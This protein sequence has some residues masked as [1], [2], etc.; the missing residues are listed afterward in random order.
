MDYN[1]WI[2]CALR[3]FFIFTML[4]NSSSSIEP[5]AKK[6]KPCCS[7]HDPRCL[8]SM[9]GKV[10]C[11]IRQERR[12]LIGLNAHSGR[13]KKYF[14]DWLNV[15]ESQSQPQTADNIFLILLYRYFSSFSS[16]LI[17]PLWLIQHQPRLHSQ[18]NY[19]LC[20]TTT[21]F[22]TA[23]QLLAS[24]RFTQLNARE[25]KCPW[26]ESC[27]WPGNYANDK[28]SLYIWHHD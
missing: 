17:I 21:L 15:K 8:P 5:W 14:C 1:E 22:W 27:W 11:H 23:F 26:E 9:L 6:R 20:K 2:D 19:T 24:Q 16:F 10:N 18:C 25:L 7:R 4:S 13:A 12:R 3:Y 28:A